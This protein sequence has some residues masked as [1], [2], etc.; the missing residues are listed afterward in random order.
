MKNNKCTA[1]ELKSI[2][3]ESIGF[4]NEARKKCFRLSSF[5][6]ILFRFM[7]NRQSRLAH[8]KKRTCLRLY[9]IL[10]LLK[11]MN[12]RL[13]T[14][15]M[16]WVHYSVLCLCFSFVRWIFTL[17]WLNCSFK[18][19]FMVFGGFD[20][21]FTSEYLFCYNNRTFLPQVK[22]I[23]CSNPQKEW[24]MRKKNATD[25]FHLP[26]HAY[27]HTDIYNVFS[28]LIRWIWSSWL[29]QIH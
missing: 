14:L 22:K 1:Y 21:F 4:E 10:N 2:K 18:F 12:L 8:G 25:F 5:V 24:Y 23:V 29:L 16:I 20:V 9:K 7:W 6:F 11:F 26:Q 17:C 19:I 27:T 3:N 13:V 15:L 28:P